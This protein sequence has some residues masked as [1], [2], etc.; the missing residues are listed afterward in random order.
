MTKKLEKHL[1][2]C[3]ARKLRVVDPVH[4]HT[5]KNIDIF[6]VGSLSMLC[7]F[8]GVFYSGT[9]SDAKAPLGIYAQ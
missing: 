9:I 5:A 8:L 3:Q 1:D 2:K 7:S 6:M 4:I